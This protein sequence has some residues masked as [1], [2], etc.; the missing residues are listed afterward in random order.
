MEGDA[1][2]VIA[3]RNCDDAA[4]ALRG[5]QALE[6]MQEPRVLNDPVRCKFSS[7]SATSD[8]VNRESAGESRQGVSK[9]TP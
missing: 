2:R 7:L 1:L 5:R 9:R 4:G 3:G 6:L 8:P